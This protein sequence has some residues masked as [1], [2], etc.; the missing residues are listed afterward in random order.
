MIKSSRLALPKS[1]PQSVLAGDPHSTAPWIRFGNFVMMGLLAGIVV[2][3]L[4]TISGAVVASGVINVETNYKTVQ[5]LDGGIVAKILVR[6]GDRVKEGMVL[7]RLDDTAARANLGVVQARANDFLAQQARL[8]AERDRRETITYPPEVLAAK[9]EPALAKIVATQEAIFQARLGSRKGEQAGLRERLAQ[10]T[11]ESQGVEMILAAR[12]QEA[13]ISASELANLKPLYDKGLINQQRYL[14]VERESARLTGDV[15]RLMSELSKSK[16]AQTEVQ[17]KIAQSEKDFTQAVVDE[18]RKVQ[19]GLAEAMEQKSALEDKLRRVDVR[20]PRN[21]RVH[22]LA[23]HTEG[24]VIQ[25]G[26][27]IMQVIPDGE[28]LI[29][30]AQ[31]APQDIDKVRQGQPAFVKF[32]AINSK[33]TPRLEASVLSVSAAQVTDNQNR[34]Y[35]TVQV[36]LAEGELAKLPA[37]HELIPGM[38]AEIYIE[39]SSRSILSYIVKPLLDAVSRTFRES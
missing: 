8:E 5:H 36:A 1:V 25:A 4:F 11:E 32:P 21:G 33:T 26:S 10:V 7:L 31:I 2:F 3:G 13:R 22:A 29:I 12:R 19:S 15:G 9:A 20:A 6:N 17:L 28:R 30:D 18:L 16:S 27:P 23:V 14:P 24:G 35:F 38:P 34:S 37:G 39:T